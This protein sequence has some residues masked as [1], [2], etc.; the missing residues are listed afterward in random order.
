D[1]DELFLNEAADLMYHY[2]LLLA[3]KGFSLEDVRSNL[4]GRHK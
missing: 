1:N 4:A 3:A 2:L